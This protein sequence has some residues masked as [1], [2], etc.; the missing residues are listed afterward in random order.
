M[1][2]QSRSAILP[3]ITR[4]DSVRAAHSPFSRP[5][6]ALLGTGPPS[7]R[8]RRSRPSGDEQTMSSRGLFPHVAWAFCPGFAARNTPKATL[9]S[10]AVSFTRVLEIL[11]RD[12]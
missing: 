4:P 7:C 12:G 11:R 10:L 1:E 6:L 5:G 2:S 3:G 8:L 9:G